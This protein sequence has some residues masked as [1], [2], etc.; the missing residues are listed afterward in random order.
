MDKCS[1]F[2][3]IEGLL[4]RG[5]SPA[6]SLDGIG[7]SDIWSYKDDFSRIVTN[8]ANGKGD[9][10]VLDDLESRFHRSQTHRFRFAD[11]HDQDFD[12]FRISKDVMILICHGFIHTII[13]SVG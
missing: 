5:S 3:S 9:F 12:G 7:T 8:I 13:K 10:L 2:P 11:Y 4:E 1:R 6:N